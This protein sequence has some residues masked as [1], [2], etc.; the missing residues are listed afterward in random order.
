MTKKTPATN[1][2]LNTMGADVLNS[3]FEL[4]LNFS[5]KFN[6]CASIPPLR[7]APNRWALQLVFLILIRII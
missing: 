1:R 6:I 3:T 7:Q 2:V 4:L 5:A